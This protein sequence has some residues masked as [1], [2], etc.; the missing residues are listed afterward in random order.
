MSVNKPKYKIGQPIICLTIPESCFIID[1]NNEYEFYNVEWLIKPVDHL[2]ERRLSF[3]VAHK[4]Y[5]EIDKT[6]FEDL[7]YAK[8]SD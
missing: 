5:K 2:G 7:Q 4:Y 8:E 3:Y 6:N 1:I